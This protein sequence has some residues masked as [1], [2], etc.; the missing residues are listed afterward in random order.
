MSI[1]RTFLGGVVVVL[2]ACGSGPDGGAP[3]A[4]KD[5]GSSSQ[6]DPATGFDVEGGLPPVGGDD[7]GSGV[8]DGAPD[9]A[10]VCSETGAV[11]GPGPYS[12]RC[13]PPTNNECD[14]HSDTNAQLPNGS[15]GNGFD[16][17]CDGI[18]DEGCTCDAAHAP[19]STRTCW[20]VPASQA[21]ATGE[22]VGFCRQNARGT[23]TCIET[24]AGEF[25]RA[26]WDGVCRGAQPAFA[27]DAC[28]PGD[29]D[30]DGVDANPRGEDCTCNDP[31]VTCPTEPLVG[32]PYPY[33]TNLE[34][35]K[36]NPLDPN[37]GKPFV[38]DGATWIQGVDPSIATGWTWTV[39]GGDCDEILPHPTFALYDGKDTTSAS[40]IGDEVSTLGPRGTQKGIASA[41]S[42]A[43]HQI[44]PAFSLSGD[45]VVTGEFD[46]KGKHYA[47]SQKVQIRWPGMRAEMCW[48]MGA[49]TVQ[50]SYGE[51]STTDVDLHVARLQGN[52]SCDGRH[53]WFDSCGPAPHADDCY[54][55]CESGCVGGTAGCG[56]AGPGWGYP[57]SSADAC[58]GWGSLRLP[59]QN[60]DNPRLDRDNVQCNVAITD[61]S[62]ARPAVFS[63]DREFCG[64]ENINVDAPAAGDQFLVGVHFFRGAEAHAH[65][66]VYC[67]GQRR[68][69]LGFAPSTPLAAA[70]PDLTSSYA[71]TAVSGIVSGDVWE[72]ARVTWNGGAD[73]CR[74]EAIPSR[75]PKADKDGTSSI[76]V[77]TNP[78][79]LLAPT[80][81][82]A[83]LFTPT[84]PTASTPIGAFC[85]H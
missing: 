2:S 51:L 32:A 28:A 29:Y 59:T 30:C 57:Q 35:K 9:V 3:G 26:M 34:Q 77:D 80:A 20:L 75:A 16:D 54:Y 25:A 24:G 62:T 13:A 8:Q 45:Y 40:Q 22:P 60:C 61:P 63:P 83:W 4:G 55:K 68:L 14:G 52:P 85:W 67:D 82:D 15:Y 27:D 11:P 47:C 72:V 48:D 73:P 37:P 18:V 36:P 41:P 70:K 78:Q 7:A 33:P 58:H 17:D 19:G 76:C 10:R 66:N 23:T 71:S 64:P 46:L 39:T 42:D 81:Q 56:T 5:A 1:A 53:G 74:I 38:V 69:A 43:Q 84:D 31:V 44:W 49:V 79:N 6:L 12:R 65:V 50:T 21:D